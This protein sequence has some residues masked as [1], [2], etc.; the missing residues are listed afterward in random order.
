MHAHSRASFFLLIPP[1]PCGVQRR[2]G[3]DGIGQTDIHIH[4]RLKID[5]PRTSGTMTSATGSLKSASSRRDSCTR[6][7][8]TSSAVCETKWSMAGV[9]L[10]SPVSSAPAICSVRAPC[11]TEP[12]LSVRRNGMDDRTQVSDGP[13]GGVRFMNLLRLGCIN[14]I[15]CGG[16]CGL[17]LSAS[18]RDDVRYRTPDN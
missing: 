3:G 8:Q 9:L 16:V 1:A 4:T 13:G 10:L 12:A 5:R 14:D 7:A 18:L 11:A 6:C 17:V 2:H 15:G